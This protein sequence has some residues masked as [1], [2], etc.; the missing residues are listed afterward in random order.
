MGT[1]TGDGTLLQK[2]SKFRPQKVSVAVNRNIINHGSM[3]NVQ[4]WLIEGSKLNYCGC[5]TQVRYTMVTE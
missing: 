5:G 3:R 1:S 2:T 4:T